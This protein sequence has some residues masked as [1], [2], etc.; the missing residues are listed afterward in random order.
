MFELLSG[1]WNVIKS[2]RRRKSSTDEGL[3]L[4]TELPKA[5]ICA[6]G[7]AVLFCCFVL[8]CVVL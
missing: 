6:Q 1:K 8:C 7:C 4:K 3:H 2:L 5:K